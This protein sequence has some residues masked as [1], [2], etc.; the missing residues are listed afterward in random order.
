MH[1][2]ITNIF[3]NLKKI[4]WKKVDFFSR[5]VR[6]M[7]L[8]GSWGEFIYGVLLL[9]NVIWLSRIYIQK[10]QRYYNEWKH[11]AESI[12]WSR[13]TS[14]VKLLPFMPQNEIFMV[15]WVNLT[16]SLV[17][18]KIWK[19]PTC[20][21]RLFWLMFDILVNKGKSTGSCEKTD[22]QHNSF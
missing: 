22:S 10:L 12:L 6:W 11:H 14:I 15:D 18:Q 4:T 1:T 19:K 8:S 21:I 7:I 13:F 16:Y 3:L 20:I 5:L 2:W 9:V 17:L